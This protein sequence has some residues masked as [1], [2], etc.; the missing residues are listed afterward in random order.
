MRIAFV[1]DSVYPWNFGGLETL[2]RVEADELAR[3]HELHFFS[4]RWPGMRKEFMKGGIRY[5]TFHDINIGKFYR[6]GR[7]SIREALMFSAG[8]LRIFRY[9][10]DVI[11]SNEFPILQLPVLKLYCTLTGCRLIVDVHE[12]WDLGYWTTYLGRVKGY[13]ANAY[14][15]WALGMADHYIANSSET[16]QKLGTLGVRKARIT[17]FAPTIDDAKMASI[18]EAAK[19]REIIFAG[20]LIKEKRLDRWLD[21]LK[22]TMKITKAKGVIIGDGPDRKRIESLVRRMKLQRSVEVRGFYSDKAAVFRR[23]KRAG[24]FLHMSE[25]EGLSTGGAGE[26]SARDAGPAPKLQPDPERREGDVHSCR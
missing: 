10:F 8:L 9:R 14:A 24:L 6:H 12:V 7:R 1:S 18:K 3:E 4:L 13:F 19:T 22:R 5:H 17:V 2:E 11:Q 26:H 25:R 20:R 16:A 15:N 23:I 21:V